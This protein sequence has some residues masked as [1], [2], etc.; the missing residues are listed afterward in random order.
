MLMIIVLVTILLAA[1]G[2]F[3][4]MWSRLQQGPLP[5]DADQAVPLADIKTMRPLA[6]AAADHQRAIEEQ[7]LAYE[8]RLRELRE[9][10]KALE[11][12]A[13]EGEHSSA[14][15]V[16]SLQGENQAFKARIAELE[17]SSLKVGQDEAKIDHL[18]V[19][20]SAFRAQV[21]EAA[22]EAAR[23]KDH[24][25]RL[26]KEA[27]EWKESSTQAAEAQKLVD[28]AKEEYQHQ[29]ENAYKQLED[30]RAQN[31]KLQELSAASAE[32]E[33][34]K[35]Q[36]EELSL[37]VREMETV[38]AIQM[39]KNEYLQYELTKSR[40]Q[41]VGLERICEGLSPATVAEK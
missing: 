20:N 8:D 3:A 15:L 37:R 13:Q 17:S 36:V 4:W 38:R 35:R 1:F 30:L 24:V 14:E 19:E 21:A 29:F 2:V 10:L 12:K 5:A 25:A 41:V 16:A 27:K 31:T 18:I 22:A 32:A 11:A 6:D 40:A 34:L 23:L 28:Q 33:T 39:E 9:E 26:E 7:R